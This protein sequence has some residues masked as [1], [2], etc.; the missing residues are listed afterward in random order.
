MRKMR[1]AQ[2]LWSRRESMISVVGFPR[3]VQPFRHQLGVGGAN[4]FLQNQFVC[5]H[6]GY[7][8]V[9]QPFQPPKCWL[10]NKISVSGRMIL[11]CR[12]LQV[13]MQNRAKRHPLMTKEASNE[14]SSRSAF[15]A[16]FTWFSGALIF[17][18][19]LDGCAS[20]RYCTAYSVSGSEVFT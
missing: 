20:G 6:V 8:M 3:F 11:L 1:L 5:K 19:A 18:I 4:L 9:E 15:P 16:S 12:T 10:A 7:H 13:D 14:A 2:W 17:L